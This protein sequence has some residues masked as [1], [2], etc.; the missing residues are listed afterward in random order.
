MPKS[1]K[2]STPRPLTAVPKPDR[3]RASRTATPGL[4]PR[5]D[6]HTYLLAGIP[7]AMWKKLLDVSD[8]LDVSVRI[9]MIKA[10]D[11]YL[12]DGTPGATDGVF[13]HLGKPRNIRARRQRKIGRAA[14]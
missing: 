3:P 7:S 4:Y 9:I 12:G 6:G 1:T 14:R 13:E 8:A 5:D 2:P 10:L 11:Y